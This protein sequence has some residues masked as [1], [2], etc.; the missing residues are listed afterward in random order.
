MQPL[1]DHEKLEVYQ[2]ARQFN[3][4]LRRFLQRVPRGNADSKLNLKRAA[5]SITRNIAEGAGRWKIADKVHFYHIARGSATECAA[6]LDEFVD[7]EI[8]PEE[9]VT[10][11]KETLS[12]VV[13]MLIAMIRSLEE[14][15][16][17]DMAANPRASARARPSPNL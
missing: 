2:L 1:F 9:R 14:R 15:D 16:R 6:S 11:L 7:W 5:Q 4:E 3:G 12:R 8:V 17:P 13:A 10:G